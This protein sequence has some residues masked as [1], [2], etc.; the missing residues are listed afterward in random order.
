MPEIR[1]SYS[2]L[3][4]GA[5]D[6]KGAVAR[7]MTHLDDLER[8]LRPIAAGWTGEASEFYR[9]KQRQWDLAAQ[10]LNEVLNSLGG[11]VQT[12]LANYQGGDSQVRQMWA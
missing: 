7:I 6:I 3:Q 8:D 10:D 9:E 1:V 2:A 11:G 5:T 4:T 12:A